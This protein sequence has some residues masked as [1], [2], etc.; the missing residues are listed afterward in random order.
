MKPDYAKAL[1]NLILLLME[2]DRLDEAEDLL[3]QSL[4][5]NPNHLEALDNLGRIFKRMG[6]GADELK[7]RRRIAALNPHDAT[8][9]NAMIFTMNYDPTSDPAAIFEE[10]RRWDERHA[11]PLRKFIQRHTNDPDPDRRLRIG[12]VSADFWLHPVSFFLR[13]LLH[14]HDRKQF[15][16]ICFS[17][18]ERPDPMTA[19]LRGDAD[20]WH[21]IRGQSD[22]AVADLIRE[23]SIDILIDLSGHS[24]QNRLLAFARRPAPVQISYLGYPATTGLSTMD[25]R[26]T[27]M[28]SDPPGGTE[29]LHTEE[30]LRLPTTNWCYAPMDSAPAAG[31]SPAATGKPICFG[32]FNNLEKVTPR[33]IALWSRILRAIPTSRLF[34]KSSGF[35]AASVRRQITEQFAAYGID[36]DRL[37]LIGREPNILTHLALYDRMDISLDTFPYHGTT[38]T[39]DALWQGV[40]VVTLAAKAH[41]SRVGV[42]L[43]NSVGLPELIAQD[44]DEYVAIAVTLANNLPRLAELRRTLRERMKASPL[45]DAPRFARNIEAAYRDVWRRWCAK[46]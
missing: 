2:T 20:A 19:I 1:N 16:I 39:C 45:M 29:H 15:E 4:T 46:T 31:R 37:D 44:E 21:D 8:A 6:R 12:Y 9:H 42:S 11:K 43:L 13:P 33:T 24:A 26:L 18:V 38:T 32:S 36:A 10:S 41:L 3:N 22:E 14:H 34:L 7:V 25:Y 40:P 17:S 30:L 28:H 27:D 5:A 35:G 23:N